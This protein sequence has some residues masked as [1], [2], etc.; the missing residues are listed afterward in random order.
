MHPP[1]AVLDALNRLFL[2]ARRNTHQ[3]SHIADFLLSWGNQ[4]VYGGFDFARI[5][6]L[7]EDICDDIG[8]LLIF[9]FKSGF[10]YPCDIGYEGKFL[11]LARYHRPD[12]CR[13]SDNYLAYVKS[14]DLKISG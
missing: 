3:A 14:E 13:V 5:R 7:D 8:T 6:C 2:K 10:Q 12:I 1:E 11:E 9:L 4:P